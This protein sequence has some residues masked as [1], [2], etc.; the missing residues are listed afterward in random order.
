MPTRGILLLLL[1]L[2][3]PLV[4]A[5]GTEVAGAL[6][7]TRTV[8][9]PLSRAQVAALVSAAW[10]NSFA[11]DP[12]AKLGS[13]ETLGPAFEGAARIAFRSDMVI[14]REQSAGSIHYRVS[15]VAENGTCQVR[16]SYIRHTG[17]TSAKSDAI[18]IGILREQASADHR[19]PGLS[20]SNAVALHNEARD[21]A[22]ARLQ[23]LLGRFES[24]LRDRAA[25]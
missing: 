23:K 7:F 6:Q 25:P 3:G 12:G 8:N 1:V 13:V 11:L 2:L 9:L 16:V 21:L 20:R 14:G 22:S 24:T 18:D 10:E 15:I 5:Q 17:S 4:H 19:I